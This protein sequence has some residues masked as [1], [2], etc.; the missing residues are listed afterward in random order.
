[1]ATMMASYV[2]GQGLQCQALH[3]M[4]LLSCLNGTQQFSSKWWCP[5]LK[6]EHKTHLQHINA[7]LMLR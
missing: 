6:A 1:M 5:V 7:T 4:T 2:P 3:A